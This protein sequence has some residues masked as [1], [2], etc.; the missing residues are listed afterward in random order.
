MCTAGTYNY[1]E[2]GKC[3]FSSISDWIEHPIN[4]YEAVRTTQ[5]SRKFRQV[6]R[7][8]CG[9]SMEPDE[10]DVILFGEIM[11]VKGE[12]NLKYL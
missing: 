11:G 7:E 6:A 10:G 3:F 2:M 12:G 5:V 1:F 8:T 4:I 9:K